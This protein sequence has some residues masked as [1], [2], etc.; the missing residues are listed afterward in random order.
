MERLQKIMAHAGVA[1][2]RECES[3]IEQGRVRVNGRLATLGDKADPAMDTIEVDGQNLNTEK[4]SFVYVALNKPKGVISSL[5]DELQ[6]GRQTVR[7]LVPLPGHLYPVGRL[8]KQSEGLILMT[9]DGDLAHKLTHPRYG[10]KKVYKVV[11]E[12]AISDQSLEKWARGGMYL[13]GRRTIPAEIEIVL[14]QRAFTHLRVTLQEGR[15][16]QIRRIANMLGHPVMELVRE[17]IGPITLGNLGSGHWRHLHDDEIKQLRES[18]KGQTAKGKRR[19]S[20]QKRHASRKKSSPTP[21]VR[22]S[23]PPKRR[24][25]R[26]SGERSK[27]SK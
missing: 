23:A 19:S 5:D 15:K 20:N 2:R 13:D 7:D 8:D 10:H 4:P 24:P 9:N 14:R 27:R 3:L 25:G 22:R 21:G 12:G 18:V 6:R 16:R 17:K 26:Q 11:V 1:S